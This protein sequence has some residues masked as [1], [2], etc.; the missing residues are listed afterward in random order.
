MDRLTFVCQKCGHEKCEC[1]IE[2]ETY[3][4]NSKFPTG[5]LFFDPS[6][7]EKE[8]TEWVLAKFE[9]DIDEIIEKE[10]F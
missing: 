5:C 9:R 4:L 6:K 3:N 10:G 1:M 7:K 8:N 2:Y